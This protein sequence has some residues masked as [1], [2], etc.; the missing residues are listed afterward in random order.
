MAKQLTEQ[1]ILDAASFIPIGKKSAIA[2]AIAQK[3]IEKVEMAV[4]DGDSVTP[5]PPRYQESSLMRMMS[6]MLIFLKNYLG[7]INVEDFTEETYNEWGSV[8]IFNQVERFKMSKNMEVRN[9]VYD[10]LDDYR[11]LCRMIGSEINSLLDANND[12][13]YRFFL[14]SSQLPSVEDIAK[15]R[16]ETADIVEEIEEYKKQ[17]KPWADNGETK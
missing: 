11:E 8:A 2:K 5:I 16:D 3:C 7:V 6:N 1:S 10:L 9:K 13:V 17:P 4:K 14:M 15:M 12:F